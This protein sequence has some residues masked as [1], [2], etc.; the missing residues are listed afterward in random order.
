MFQYFKFQLLIYKYINN[1]NLFSY[2]SIRLTIIILIYTKLINL[3]NTTQCS[4]EEQRETRPF[5]SMS[6]KRLC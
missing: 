1:S 3:L 5:Y 6:E 2:C 4:C